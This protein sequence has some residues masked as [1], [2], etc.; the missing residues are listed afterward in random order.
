M[1]Q[2]PVYDTLSIHPKTAFFHDRY[3]LGCA[4][5]KCRLQRGGGDDG[6]VDSGERSPLAAPLPVAPV[7]VGRAVLCAQRAQRRACASRRAGIIE[8]R[9]LRTRVRVSNI[10]PIRKGIAQFQR[11][12]RARVLCIGCFS[13]EQDAPSYPRT[14]SLHPL[15]THL[16]VEW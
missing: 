5:A 16:N 7:A 14:L 10:G 15:E 6:G 11:T 8:L 2:T 12:T 13:P 3:I 1:H 4:E 9:V